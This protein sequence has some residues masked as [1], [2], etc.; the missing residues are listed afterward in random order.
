MVKSKKSKFRKNR[1]PKGFIPNGAR[2]KKINA[3]TAFDTCSEQLSP[4][5]GL[6]PLIKFLDLVEFQENI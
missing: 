5:G 2:A 3:S 4:F 6:L 1:N